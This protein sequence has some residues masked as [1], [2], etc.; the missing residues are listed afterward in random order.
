MLNRVHGN[1]VTSHAQ[2]GRLV[3]AIF[4]IFCRTSPYQ[5]LQYGV[6]YRV[7]ELV[8][9]KCAVQAEIETSGALIIEMLPEKAV[10]GNRSIAVAFLYQ[11]IT[12]VLCCAIRNIP[13]SCGVVIRSVFDPPGKQQPQGT[14]LTLFPHSRPSLE[15]FRL[16]ASSLP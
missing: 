11:T 13:G 9:K 15:L 10:F 8:R 14:P 4:L 16:S 6:C 2:K 3:A 12:Y 1:H 7:Q 5:T